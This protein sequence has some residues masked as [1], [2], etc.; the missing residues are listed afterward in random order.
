MVLIVLELGNDVD[1]GYF[2]PFV[3]IFYV[4]VLFAWLK[5]FC[6]DLW[7]AGL[8]GVTGYFRVLGYLAGIG[9]YFCW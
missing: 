5:V 4:V 8:F 2:E 9:V 3:G 1:S 6:E 7:D